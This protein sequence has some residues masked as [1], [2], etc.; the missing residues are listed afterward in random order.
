MRQ[1][2]PHAGALWRRW[3]R[4]RAA[5]L[6]DVSAALEHIV[7]TVVAEVSEAFRMTIASFHACKNMHVR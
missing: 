4:V 6:Y 2:E 1:I 7:G 3:R 5:Q